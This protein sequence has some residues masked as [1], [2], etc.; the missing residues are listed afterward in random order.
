MRMRE[1]SRHTGRPISKW[2]DSSMDDTYIPHDHRTLHLSLLLC[3]LPSILKCDRICEN[4]ACSES[5]RIT[6]CAFLVAQVEYY[7]SLSYSRERTFLL[8]VSVT[9]AYGGK[10]LR[11]KSL[12]P[13]QA[14]QSTQ[15]VQ[16]QCTETVAKG[17][18]QNSR[19]D[20]LD[21]SNYCTLTH[22]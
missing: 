7:P 1:R 8:T 2:Y 18:N 17:A 4:P 15:F 13:F 12:I 10:L 20:Y 5:A 16:L 6:Q 11:R 3:L 22:L 21:L 9:V 19:A 14:S